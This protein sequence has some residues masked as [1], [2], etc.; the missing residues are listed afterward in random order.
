MGIVK[1][2][3]HMHDQVRTASQVMERSI[4]AQAEFWLKIGQQAELHPT[5]TFSEIIQQAFIEQQRHE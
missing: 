1:I 5:K 3:E 4:N 2:S